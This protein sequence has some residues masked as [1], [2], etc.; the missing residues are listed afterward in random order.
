MVFIFRAY[1]CVLFAFFVLLVC[2][3]CLSV[4]PKFVWLSLLVLLWAVF[5]LSFIYFYYY[6][7]FFFFFWGVCVC[8]FCVFFVCFVVVLS[9]RFIGFFLLGLFFEGLGGF[10]FVCCFLGGCFVFI[11]FVLFCLFVF[12][13][14]LSVFF[15]VFFP[16]FCVWLF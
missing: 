6:F 4:L 2:R 3:I 11:L 7:F 5:W 10:L 9:C 13:V 16:F 14:F 8:G 12:V 1:Y 15:G